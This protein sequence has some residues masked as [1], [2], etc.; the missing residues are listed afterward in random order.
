V[1]QRAQVRKIAGRGGSGGTLDY[2]CAW[3]LKAGDYL[4]HS[5]ANIGFVAT[6]SITQGEQVAQLW[7]LLFNR[8]A[9]EIAFAH[10]T[11]AWGSDARGMAHVHVVIIGLTKREG[12]PKEKRLF[13]YDDITGDPVESRHAALSPYLFDASGLSDRHLVVMEIS[14]PLCNSPRMITGTQPIDGGHLIFDAAE[15]AEFV[16]KEPGAKKFLRPFLGTNEF[17][18]GIPRWILAVQNATPQELRSLSKVRERLRLV[19]EI[20]LESHR[21]STLKIADYPTRFNVETIPAVPFLAVPEVS[22]EQ[23]DYV[24]I[25]WLEPPVIPSNKLRLIENAKLWQFGILTSAMHMAWTRIVGGRLESRYQYSV[26]INYNPFPWPELDDSDK[27]KLVKLAQKLLDARAVH[28]GAT[29]ADL[30]DPTVM[31]ADLRRAHQALDLAVDKLYR[32]T[33]FQSD[34]ERVQ[35]LFGLY[36]KLVAPLTAVAAAKPRTRRAR[37]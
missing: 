22:S 23:R 20:R 5:D 3:F 31:P 11:F 7:P 9:L 28:L 24:P 12:E 26:G 8:C 6:N 19:T 30:Y 33:P 32:T 36:E 34:R 27:A 10:R 15:Y 1:S 14:R 21:K 13:S 18:N 17:L 4:K 25:G 16:A 29:L 35:H 2:V 37:R